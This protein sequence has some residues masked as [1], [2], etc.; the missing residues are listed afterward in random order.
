MEPAM[1]IAVSLVIAIA[2]GTPAAAQDLAPVALNSLSATPA[3]IAAAPVLDQN[4]AVI[5]KVR[6]IVTDQDGKPSAMSCVAGQRVAVIAAQAV[7]YDAQ[8]NR[9]IADTSKAKLGDQV[10]AN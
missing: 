7:S 2:L 4:G 5:G 9:V 3:R 10:A 6:A 1:K 8:K